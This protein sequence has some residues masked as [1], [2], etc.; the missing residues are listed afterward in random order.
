MDGHDGQRD[1]RSV[2]QG[3]PSEVAERRLGVVLEGW[4][5]DGNEV[6]ARRQID[7]VA[8]R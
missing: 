2:Y 4:L 6:V 3:E 8:T 5:R 1:L 7:Q